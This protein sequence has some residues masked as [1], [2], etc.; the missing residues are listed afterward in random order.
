M[1]DTDKPAVEDT[2]EG[3]TESHELEGA[4]ADQELEGE[5]AA[6]SGAAD[7]GAD[8]QVAQLKDQLLRSFAEV[9][10][11]KRRAQR[12]VENAHKYAVE[13]LINDLFPVIDSLEKA[14]ETANATE[15]A[16]PIAEGV[17][18]SMKLFLD[19]LAKSGVEQVDPLGLPF[20]PQE[21]EAMT[22]VPNP[23]AR[24]QFG[25]GCNGKGL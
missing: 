10:N 6:P 2:G 5:G 21:H 12:D 7:E 22:M 8:E 1:A 19:T 23:D 18:L 4:H 17:S 3:S 9:E 25:H 16:D 20:D 24:A 13:K 11:I 15:G 14:V